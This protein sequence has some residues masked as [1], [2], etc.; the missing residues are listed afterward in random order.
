MLED[1]EAGYISPDL[2]LFGD[3]PG[4]NKIFNLIITLKP[5]QP[6]FLKLAFT[7]FLPS[8]ILR[9]TSRFELRC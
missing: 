9:Q 6:Y 3:C 8:R 1:A 5:E 4:K 2:L 7:W